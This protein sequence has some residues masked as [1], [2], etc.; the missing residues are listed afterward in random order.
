M[1][2]LTVSVEDAHSAIDT[3]L[4]PGRGW[5]TAETALER[6]INQNDANGYYKALGLPPSATRE[7]IKAAYRKLALKLH[8]DLGGDKELFMFVSTI[9]NVLLNREEKAIYDSVSDQAIYLGNMELEELARR[10][11][12]LDSIVTPESLHWACLT[13][14]EF[15][16]GN[17]TDAWTELC[18]EV[19]PAVGYRGKI[20]VGVVGGGFPHQAWNIFIT[21]THTFVVFQR[22]VEPNRLHALCAMI[23]LQKHLQKQTPQ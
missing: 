5:L 16:P 13:D 14:R 8:P 1:T 4:H 9:A 7:E 18:R 10:G 17:D 23:D 21:G 20:Q 3:K 15:L 12:K 2:P 6:L 11:I 22:G 19:A